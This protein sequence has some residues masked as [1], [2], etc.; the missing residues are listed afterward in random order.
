MCTLDKEKQGPTVVGVGF[1]VS[2]IKVDHSV[3]ALGQSSEVRYRQCVTVYVQ[4]SLSG[5]TTF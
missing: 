4:S 1:N 5:L 2:V 3:F